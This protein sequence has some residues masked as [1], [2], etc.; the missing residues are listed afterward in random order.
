MIRHIL[1]T[2]S[3]ALCIAVVQA[4]AVQAQG[5]G[6][7]MHLDVPFA[8]TPHE[9]VAEMLRLAEVGPEDV[10]YDLGSGDGRIVIAA[11]RDFGARAAVGIDLDPRRVEEG[12][13][14][15]EK[16]GV[17]ARTR[18][19]RDDIFKADFSEATVLALYLTPRILNEAAPR[20]LEQLKPG[21]RIVTYRFAFR[22][23]I[24]ARE[25]ELD[26]QPIRV[27]IVPGQP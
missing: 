17:A 25:T 22:D 9:A 11:A 12:Q 10:V 26:G 8:A 19:L 6:K 15:A 27:W 2:L 23:W 7:M 5:R 14:N 18:F 3:V 4:A 20:F 21:S 1:A 24:P 13:E 16:A